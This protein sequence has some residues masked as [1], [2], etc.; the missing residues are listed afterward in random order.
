MKQSRR[1]VGA[2]A[3]ALTIAAG[4]PLEGQQGS[5]P[6]TP[7]PPSG[8]IVAPVFDGWYQNPDGTFTFSFGYF[9]RNTE[10]IVEIP[11]GPNN[12]IEP[13]EFNGI[14][15]T[16]FP[17]VNYGGFSGR[18]ERGTFAVT[19]PADFGERD[20]VWTLTHRGKTYSVP[21]RSTYGAYQLSHTPQAAG[22]LPPLVKVDP[23][24]EPI[25]GRGP[26]A[27]TNLTVRA[28][29]PV[30]LWVWGEDRGERES[31]FQV[32]A[33]WIKHQGPGDI[34]FEPVT[35][36]TPEAPG[37]ELTTSAVFSAPGEYV[38]RVRVDNFTTSDSSFADQCCWSNGFYRVTVTE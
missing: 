28:G 20:V 26:E 36:R 18:R 30:T 16:H 31:R 23:N 34:A 24:A 38:V 3:V 11:I 12:F 9:N 32:N 13:A 37:G 25:F 5:L 10:E 21:G 7:L 19:V 8:D 17:P 35:A 33:T 2:L 14:Q 27:S 6:L 15:P 29:Q 22:T 4:A 1:A